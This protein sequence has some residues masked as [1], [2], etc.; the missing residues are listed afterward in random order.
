MNPIFVELCIH[1]YAFDGIFPQKF[2]I[3]KSW[4]KTHVGEDLDLNTNDLKVESG[5][6]Q[7]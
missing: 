6:G 7:I 1:K 2:L 3:V 5:S 4:Q